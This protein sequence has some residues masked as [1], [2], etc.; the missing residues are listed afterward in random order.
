MLPMSTSSC[1]SPA[2]IW[3]VLLIGSLAYFRSVSSQLSLGTLLLALAL[4]TITQAVSFTPGS[5][6]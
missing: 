1:G 4:F 3:A 6:G 2:A 5:V